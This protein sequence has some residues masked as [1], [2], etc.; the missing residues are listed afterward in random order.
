MSPDAS[1]EKQYGDTSISIGR[2]S[3]GPKWEAKVY[4]NGRAI[5][6]VLD[7]LKTAVEECESV[8]DRLQGNEEEGS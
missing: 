2:T 5:T 1:V 7:D 8:C 3:R 6:E 4:A